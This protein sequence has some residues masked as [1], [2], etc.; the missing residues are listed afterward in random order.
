MKDPTPVWKDLAHR[1]QFDRRDVVQYCIL[2]A[3]R[4]KNPDKLAVA[5]GFLQTAFSPVTN[6]RRLEN[7]AQ[8]YGMV[9]TPVYNGRGHILTNCLETDE[10][11]KQYTE[12]YNQA[13]EELGRQYGEHHAFFIVRQDI[14]PEQQLVQVGHAALKL[15]FSLGFQA[16]YHRFSDDSEEPLVDPNELNFVVCGVKSKEEVEGAANYI[17]SCG[18][19][20]HKFYEPDIGDEVTAVASGP[21]K[22]HKRSFMKRYKRLRFK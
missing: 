4:A 21:V 9:Y 17:Y 3:L 20:I 16:A 10:E 15:G 14:I 11:R 7:G 19:S 18:H 12:L 2:R 1:K 8:P 5:V 6:P 22:S 13:L